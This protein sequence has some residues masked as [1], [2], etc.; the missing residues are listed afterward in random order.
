[1]QEIQLRCVQEEGE[2]EGEGEG[3]GDTLATLDIHSLIQ[4]THSL[5]TYL[6]DP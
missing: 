2:E 6:N 4:P 1:M 3:E 5:H